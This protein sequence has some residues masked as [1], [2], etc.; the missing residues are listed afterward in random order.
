MHG[1][2]SDTAR[3]TQASTAQSLLPRERRRN[4][5][6]PLY[7]DLARR[8]A[9]SIETGA[10]RVG[11]RLPS[12]RVLRAQ[13][14][15]STATVIQA[16]ARLES[17]G[18]AE[19][20]PRSGYFVR[21]RLLL[22]APAATRPSPTPRPVTVAA[23]ATRIIDSIR[24]ERLVALGAAVPDPE[25]LPVAAL[26]RALTSVSRP[27]LGAALTYEATAG[28]EGLR[29]DIARRAVTW[30]FAVDPDDVVVTAGASEAIYLAL[31]AVTKP[32]E[33]VA[34]EAPAYHG[35]LQALETLGLRAVEVPCNAETGLD[36]EAL[37]RIVKCQRVAA[38]LAV[39]NFSN[40]MGSLMP[41]PAKRRLVRILADR[42]LPLVE[43]DVYGDLSFGEGRP[44]SAKAFDRDGLVLTCSSFS[45]TLAPGW[46]VGFILPGRFRESVHRHKY[47]LNLTTSSAPQRAVARFLETGAYDRHLRRLRV[48]VAGTA[49][50]MRA[51]I[52]ASFPVGTRVSRPAGGFVLWVEL[53]PTVD[54][55]DLYARALDAGVGLVPGQMFSPHGGCQHFVRISYAHVWND[56]I[57]RAVERVGSI[58][59]RMARAAPS[60]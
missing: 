38:V 59:T 12:V 45:K 32:G 58:A 2:G 11:D 10:L 21:P 14:R 52:T 25:L 51:T 50:Q 57:R 28:F 23:L 49:Q 4:R 13:E 60:G 41:E 44:P 6:V 9:R 42:Q 36:L 24:D 56:R 22:P 47:A 55:L 5:S 46:R 3:G 33:S 18:L 16:F 39:P 26:S 20:R 40:P 15:V 43:D 54:G 30:G 17:L 1:P 27:G 31:R 35:T 8:F 53:P 37:E 34:I 19:S 29:R 7:E 48:V